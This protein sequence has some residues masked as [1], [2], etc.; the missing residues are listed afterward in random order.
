MNLEAHASRPRRSSTSH[1][2]CDTAAHVARHIA[3]HYASYG[4]L[5]SA[6]RTLRCLGQAPE[7]SDLTTLHSLVTTEHR[8]WPSWSRLESGGVTRDA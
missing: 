3:R 7:R 4:D 8:R 5:E 6:W 2:E 1:S